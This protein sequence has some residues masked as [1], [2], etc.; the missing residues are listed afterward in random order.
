MVWDFLPD[1]ICLIMGDSNN[2]SFY[3]QFDVLSFCFCIE[4]TKRREMKSIKSLQVISDHS[5]QWRELYL[6]VYVTILS[7]IE[8]VKICC[9]ALE[10]ELTEL[11]EHCNPI[12]FCCWPFW[13]MTDISSFSWNL[14]RAPTKAKCWFC[15]HLSEI[16][17]SLSSSSSLL[18]SSE[19]K[20]D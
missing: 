4:A 10:G 16:D 11:V 13:V 2:T 5:L 3:H 1:I 12:K 19:V 15:F 18:E 8:W 20:D 17:S 6:L 7:R 9:H 14:W